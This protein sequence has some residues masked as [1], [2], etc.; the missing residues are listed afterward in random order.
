[1]TGTA[2]PRATVNLLLTAATDA[3][4]PYQAGASLGTGPIIVDIR[5]IGLSPDALLQVSVGDFWPWVCPGY[6]GVLDSRGQAQAAIKIPN[7]AALVGT[8]FHPAFVTLDAQAPSGI[9]SIST[10]ATR[11]VTT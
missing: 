6:R 5:Q 7:Y 9:R 3:G 4:L 2:R 11:I 10:T 8:R 1:M